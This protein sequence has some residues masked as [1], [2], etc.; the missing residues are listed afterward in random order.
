M[1][2]NKACS[3]RAIRINV[4]CVWGI[5]EIEQQLGKPC[6]IEGGTK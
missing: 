2:P 5:S 6:V 3:E 1:T 4:F